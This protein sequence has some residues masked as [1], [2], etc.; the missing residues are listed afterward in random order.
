M[1]I[2][3][4]VNA[5]T[6]N[7]RRDILPVFSLPQPEQVTPYVRPADWLTMPTVLS[8]DQKI[9]LLVGVDNVS[10]NFF[11]VTCTTSSGTYTINW[12]DGT[13]DDVT[14]SNVTTYHNFNWNNVSSGTLTTKGYRQVIVTITP[15]SGNLLTCLFTPTFVGTIG[16]VTAGWNNKILESIVAGSN[17]TQV[18]FSGAGQ[19]AM[20]MEQT[21]VL[22]LASNASLSGMY[23]NCKSLQSVVSFPNGNYT[24]LSSMFVSCTSLQ[25]APLFTFAT[26]GVNMGSMFA[27]CN[28]L[29]SVP[30]YNTVGVT[31]MAGMFSGCTKI[32]NIPFFNTT[33]VTSM[34][35]MFN[36]CLSLTSVP[37]FDTRLVTS[38][39]QMFANCFSLKTCP[40][41]NTIL[42][43][44]MDSMFAGCESL[45]GAP[46]FNTVA[47]TNAS[48]MF[49]TCYSL[50]TAPSYNLPVCTTTALMFSNCFNLVSIGNLTTS[51]ALVSMLQTFL[52]CRSLITAPNISNTTNVTNTAELFYGCSSIT[53]IPNY[54]TANVTVLNGMFGFTHSLR[55]PPNIDTSK[56]TN[57]TALFRSSGITTAPAYN[58]S[59]VTNMTTTFFQ[60]NNLQTMHTYDTA[61]VTIMNATFQATPSLIEI[62]LMNTSRVTNFLNFATQSA[63]K[64][65]ANLNT[66]NANNISG[67]FS[68]CVNLTT[69]PTFECANV[70]SAATAFSTSAPLNKVIASNLRV[71][72]S[73]ASD[74]I[75]RVELEELMINLGSNVSGQTLTVGPNPGADTPV[76]RTG[77][78]FNSGSNVVPMANTVGL[79][80]GM[81]MSP[82]A[83]VTTVATT[84]T[85]ANS[86]ISLPM[87]LPDNTMVSLANVATSNLPVNTIFYTTYVN[88]SPPT[89]GHRLSL[90]PGG[91]NVTFTSG[92]GNVRLAANITQ[93][94][95]NSNVIL[96]Y[97]ISGSATNQSPSF[98]ILNTNMATFKGWTVTG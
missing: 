29:L 58:S 91:A 14:A 72:T 42:V 22:S 77:I 11:A 78:V 25:V 88:G 64:R 4:A 36:N 52:Q 63:V 65:V 93:I 56:S 94:N 8:T 33:N 69:L 95:T 49:S 47:V 79:S 61:N 62:P 20:W 84:L 5:G 44:A 35:T 13:S 34:A 89:V 85:G 57:W 92:I 71:S 24:N 90:T 19:Q 98:R 48:S 68:S 38:M 28:N 54:N 23:S 55:T 6:N 43:T 59:N 53:T 39:S 51:G 87:Q 30:E 46:P 10:T 7:G 40:T 16:S 81:I 74:N 97:I 37:P 73:V 96:N 12:G 2:N 32:N 82:I 26:S 41:F 67:M 21:T 83:N 45:I 66:S 17:I 18:Q 70:T 9:V 86:A 15:T 3:R 31:T 60:C 75:G 1:S 50:T 27:N 76:A 80:V